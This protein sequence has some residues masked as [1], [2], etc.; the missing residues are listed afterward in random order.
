MAV[1]IKQNRVPVTRFY[2]LLMNLLIRSNKD[3]NIRLI[4][5]KNILNVENFIIL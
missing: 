2:F 3:L 4:E 1:Y 5:M